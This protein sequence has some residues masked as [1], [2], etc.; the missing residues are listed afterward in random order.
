MA[1][2]KSIKSNKFYKV[3]GLSHIDFLDNNNLKNINFTNESNFNE[4]LSRIPQSN[5][6]GFRSFKNEKDPKKT[7]SS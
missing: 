3:S 2:D 4:N 5:G 7:R 6:N 1:S